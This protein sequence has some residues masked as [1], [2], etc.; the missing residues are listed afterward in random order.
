MLVQ[1]CAQANEDN[2]TSWTLFPG[3]DG[4]TFKVLCYRCNKWGHYASRYTG[5]D[6]RVCFSSLQYGFTLAQSERAPTSVIPKEWILLDSCST[7]CAFIDLDLLHNIFLCASIK[8]NSRYI[9][10]VA[11]LHTYN[12]IGMFKYLP[13][14]AYYNQELIANI[15]SLKQL[16]YLKN[17]NVSITQGPSSAL[18]LEFGGR[19][20]RFESCV[21]GLFHCLSVDFISPIS[22]TKHNKKVYFHQVHTA[23]PIIL[24]STSN[25]REALF[26][27]KE[28]YQAKAARLLQEETCWP[29]DDIFKNSSPT[30]IL[31]I[32]PSLF[33]MST[34]PI[35]CMSLSQA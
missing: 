32:V 33:K 27:N 5:L 9:L 18:F 21:G 22:S 24:L 17:C 10:I 30:V 34:E 15:L 20:V 2:V 1:Q 26:T 3:A 23:I 25:N 28:I 12:E 4:C 16:L 8:I 19:T 11:P 29:S 31:P 35:I 7:D 14:K 13:L 6:T